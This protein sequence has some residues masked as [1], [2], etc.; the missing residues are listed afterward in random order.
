[1]IIT[2]CL[3]RVLR[4]TVVQCTVDMK[5]FLCNVYNFQTATERGVS[6]M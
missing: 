3:S 4:G 1:M 6:L 2:L 5:F